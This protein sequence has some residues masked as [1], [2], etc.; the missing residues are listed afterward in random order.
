VIGGDCA[1]GSSLGSDNEVLQY[2]LASE[3]RITASFLY[4]IAERTCEGSRKMECIL[5]KIQELSAET[6]QVPHP[7]PE[8]H[9]ELEYQSKYCIFSGIRLSRAIVLCRLRQLYSETA[10]TSVATS[11]ERSTNGDKWK[12]VYDPAKKAVDDAC[13]IMVAALGCICQSIDL[14]EGHVIQLLEPFPK[15]SIQVQ[16]GNRNFRIGQIHPECLVEL[17]VHHESDI[18][19]RMANRNADKNNFAASVGRARAAESGTKPREEV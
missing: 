3:A 16:A 19:T 2:A 11:V 4:E 18:E 14:P 13:F 17:L 10:V 15:N 1:W 7:A 6:T 12:K 9:G 8:Q 5:A